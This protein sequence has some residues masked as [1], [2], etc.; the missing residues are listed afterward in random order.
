MD[1]LSSRLKE[2]GIECLGGGGRFVCWGCIVFFFFF[3]DVRTRLEE[4]GEVYYF[5]ESL[6]GILLFLVR[7]RKET[8]R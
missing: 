6:P 1:Y 7:G 3:W 4:G 2:C 5:D 8:E